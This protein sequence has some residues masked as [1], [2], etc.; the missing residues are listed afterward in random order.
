[1]GVQKQNSV[2]YLWYF[3]MV[4]QTEYDTTIFGAQSLML[5][6]LTSFFSSSI[7]HL[8][9]LVFLIWNGQS[10]ADHMGTYGTNVY[11]TYGAFGQFTHE[12]NG[13]ELFSVDL[14]K[15]GDCVEAA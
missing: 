9:T 1:M 5:S 8:P 11:Q 15:K 2:D 12:F 3:V 14:R 10:P 4:A 7:S 13:N 6:C